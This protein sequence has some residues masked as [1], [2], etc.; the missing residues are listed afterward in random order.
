VDRADPG[1]HPGYITWEQYEANQQALLDNAAAATPTVRPGPAREST[2]QLQRPGHL[3]A[4]RAA[5]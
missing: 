3:R 2:A 4:V 5:E 1:A